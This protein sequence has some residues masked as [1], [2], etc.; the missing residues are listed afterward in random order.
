V[1]LLESRFVERQAMKGPPKKSAFDGPINQAATPAIANE[2]LNEIQRDRG[3]DKVIENV[4]RYQVALRRAGAGAAP[5]WTGEVVGPPELYPLRTVNVL[6]AGKTITVFNKNHKK[7]WESVLNYD[8]PR[9]LAWGEDSRYGQGPC[10]ERGEALYV[11]DQGVLS[12]F[13][14]ATGQARWRLPSVGVSGLFFDD[15]GMMYVNTTTASPDNIKYSRQI[16]VTEKK[17]LVVLKVDPKKGKTL[18]RTESAGWVIYVSGN[19][20]YTL[21]MYQAD[22]EDADVLGKITTGLEVPSHMR[23]KRL[24]PRKG[25]VLWERYQRSCPLDVQFDKNSIQLVFRKEVQVLKFISL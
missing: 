2:I 3:G 10:A 23:I 25:R 4:S 17:A 15:A 20:F 16:D 8:V 12:A 9:G 14:L 11:F 5:T 1:Q 19:F 24:D 7:L 13:E 21:E 6:A 22:D 18:W